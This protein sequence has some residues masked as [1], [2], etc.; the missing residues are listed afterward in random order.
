M[1]NPRI[2]N[3]IAGAGCPNQADSGGYKV[4]PVPTPSS[5]SLDI[6]NK[7][8]AAGNNQNLRL[9]NRAK[10]ISGA[11]SRR[12]TAQLPKNPIIKG[13]TMKKIIN[14]PC[15]VTKTL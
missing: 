7:T 4:Q 12:G 3:S 11:A 2:I 13:I 6:S 14:N 1:C 10:T 5:T 9:F 15:E 8:V